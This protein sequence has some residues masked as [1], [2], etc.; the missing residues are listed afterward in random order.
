VLAPIGRVPSALTNIAVVAKNLKVVDVEFEFGEISAR[1][2]MIDVQ[3]VLGGWA[4]AATLTA[5]AVL[6]KRPVP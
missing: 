3:D 6:Q 2:D 5:A 4:A 1:L